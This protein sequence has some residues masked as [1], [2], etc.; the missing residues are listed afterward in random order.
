MPP[1][2]AAG[3]EAPSAMRSLG[4]GIGLAHANF[5]GLYPLALGVDATLE[6][7][8]LLLGMSGPAGRFEHA[9]R[10][11]HGSANAA[12][13]AAIALFVVDAF[14]PP[15]LVTAL[16]ARAVRERLRGRPARPGQSLLA[17]L[18]GVPVAAATALALA[19]VPVG[20]IWIPYAM[21]GE[22]FRRFMTL[23]AI[24]HVVF[25]L[26]FVLIAAIVARL[27]LATPA[28]VLEGRGLLAAW[29]RSETLIE[30]AMRRVLGLV[31][32]VGLIWVVLVHGVAGGGATWLAERLPPHDTQHFA[33]TAST[34]ATLALAFARCA[35]EAW[36]HLLVGVVTTVLFERA[37]R[38]KD[39]PDP[40]ELKQ[41]FA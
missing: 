25:L 41:V 18:R 12:L 38:A 26:A 29:R 39:G 21:F 15:L 19:I 23:N 20:S 32:V 16:I 17:G 10:H 2:S 35:F 11:L 1:P 5:L 40:D 6:G 22:A 13:F 31:L 33:R 3:A 9:G 28:A 30:G 27:A 34:G 8:A 4:D 24:G 14:L 7:I 37:R 36:F